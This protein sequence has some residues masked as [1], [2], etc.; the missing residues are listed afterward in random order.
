MALELDNDDLEVVKAARRRQL[1]DRFDRVDQAIGVLTD[2]LG[3]LS[4]ARSDV[5]EQL[6]DLEAGD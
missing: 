5:V 4:K 3:V 1:L 6:R 2:Q